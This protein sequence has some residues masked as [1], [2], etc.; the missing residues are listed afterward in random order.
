MQVNTVLGPVESG[1]LGPTL[2]HEH[3]TVADH[4][5][6]FALGERFY[7]AQRVEDTAVQ[8]LTRAREDCG[9][10]TIVDG[11]AI[12]LGRDLGLLQR[13]ARRSGVHIV[14]SSGFY[15]QDDPW[16]SFIKRDQAYDV[17]LDECENGMEGTGV[18]PGILKCAVGEPGFTRVIRMVFNATGRVSAKTGLPIFVH[19]T[20]S[21]KDGHEA[22]DL[23]EAAG[24]DLRRVVAG[25]CGDSTD[26][27]Y[28]ESLL[29]RGCY[30]GIDRFAHWHR[31]PDGL[32]WRTGVVVEM[33]RRG[34][35]Q[36][37]LLSHDLSAYTGFN[38]T[39]A[40]LNRPDHVMTLK[41]DYCVV[42]EKVVPLLLQLGVGQDDVD[43]MLVHNVQNLF[44]GH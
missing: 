17:L 41:S 14:A 5:L 21:A 39:M 24:A 23:L 15:F 31:E 37:L 10:R 38:E 28:L 32:Q 27:D 1:A 30:L 42:H 29:K 3:V 4:S 9:V 2:I 8:M 44:E 36:R 13:V 11:T 35:A 6:R 34:W 16:L 40:H 19:T 7:N 25:H 12:N 43:Q 26:Y 22:L 20:P 18:L 33:V